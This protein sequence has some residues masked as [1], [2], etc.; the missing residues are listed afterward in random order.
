MT[1]DPLSELK[2]A[3]CMLFSDVLAVLVC[4]FL[5]CFGIKLFDYKHLDP[6]FTFKRWMGLFLIIYSLHAAVF[7]VLP[8][9]CK[10]LWNFA[11]N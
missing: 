4:S 9:F 5:L 1:L 11:S 2:I 8:L 7:S 10:S 3:S 6:F